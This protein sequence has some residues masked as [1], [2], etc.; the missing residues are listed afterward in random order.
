MV[1]LYHSD[2]REDK[3]YIALISVERNIGKIH[4]TISLDIYID[5]GT[6]NSNISLVD[7]NIIII[8]YRG[9]KPTNNELEYLALLYALGHI[10]SKYRHSEVTI[11][12]DSQLVVNQ[13]NGKW[14]VTTDA[15]IKLNDK[16]KRMITNK[17]KIVWVPREFN[18]A[19]HVLEKNCPL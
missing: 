12:S 13:M 14:R 19:G 6:R 10:R 7:G 1:H 17:I 15:L 2:I 8:K 16:C 4:N 11:Y 9:N 18:L 5:G 3:K